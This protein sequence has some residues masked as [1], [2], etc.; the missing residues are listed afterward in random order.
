[1]P[2]LRS[3]G[4][5][6]DLHLFLPPSVRLDVGVAETWP[7]GDGA[8]R[9]SSLRARLAAL[10]PDVVFVPT[11]RWIDCG[12]IPVVVMVRNMEPIVTPLKGNPIAEGINVARAFEARRACRRSRRVIAVSNYVR[13]VLR[14]R[15][16][17]D[18]R[19]IGVVYHGVERSAARAAPLR[20]SL[21]SPIGRSCSP[22][23]RSARRAASRTSSRRWRR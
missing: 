6:S 7:A 4:A 1:M 5:I 10:S 3:H 21:T 13:D 16:Q 9:F 23:G 12:S 15:W 8:R 11:A 14:A 20:R 22:L 17:L 18:E 19:K 2:L